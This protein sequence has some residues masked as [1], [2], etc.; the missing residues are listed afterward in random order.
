MQLAYVFS[1]FGY[2]VAYSFVRNE[3]KNKEDNKNLYTQAQEKLAIGMTGYAISK[4]IFTIV[5][6][7]T[8]GYMGE[9][10]GLIV[11]W[12]MCFVSLIMHLVI[13]LVFENDFSLWWVVDGFFWGLQSAALADKDNTGYVNS[14]TEMDKNNTDSSVV[15]KALFA[16]LI[17]VLGGFLRQSNPVWLMLPLMGLFILIFVLTLLNMIRGS[18]TG[19][20]IDQLMNTSNQANAGSLSEN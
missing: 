16:I 6:S 18:Q 13:A 7:K 11:L 2:Q 4:A 17:F 20:D 10:I 3:E 1:T 8:Y 5:F 9:K 19:V 14:I 15:L 12:S